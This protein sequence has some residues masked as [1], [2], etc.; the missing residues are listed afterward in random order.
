M[1][2]ILKVVSLKLELSRL[3]RLLNKDINEFFITDLENM[4][5]MHGEKEI[6]DYLKFRHEFVKILETFKKEVHVYSSIDTLKRITAV[7]LRKI[8][9][10]YYDIISTDK[11][12]A[13]ASYILE[14]L[15]TTV[16][17]SLEFFTLVEA[18]KLT[19]KE[20]L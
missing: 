9:K 8:S 12:F 1:F 7:Y 2:N 3:I 15:I 5:L 19:A 10:R 14:E 4:M 13:R 6:T 11:G 20:H 17:D 16:S 18:Q